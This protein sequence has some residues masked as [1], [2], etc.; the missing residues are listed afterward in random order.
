M[1]LN[2]KGAAGVQ[3]ADIGAVS[4]GM[5]G[6]RTEV[7][8]NGGAAADPEGVGDSDK[9]GRS[10]SSGTGIEVVEGGAWTEAGG[11]TATDGKL[12]ENSDL[13]AGAACYRGCVFS[14]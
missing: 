8:V 10:L 14:N 12:S 3:G 1:F 6:G 4:S 5:G 11:A 2:V 9:S 13:D 7:E